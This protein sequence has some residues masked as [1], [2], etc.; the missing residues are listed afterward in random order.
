[1]DKVKNV[2]EIRFKGFQDEWKEVEL[3]EYVIKAVDNRGKTPLISQNGRY[4]LIEVISL[5]SSKP[6]YS[7]CTKYLNED[8]FKNSLRG[9]VQEE[10]I[11]FSTVGSIGLVS[12]MDDNKK[13]AIAQNIVAFRTL[14][15]YNPSFVFAMF[16]TYDNKMRT[17]KIVMSAVQPSIKVSQL[18]HVK[19]FITTN[20]EEQ[21][22]IGNLLK[23]IDKKLE[24][25]KE[26]HEKLTNFKKAMLEEVFPKEGEN[27]PKVRF[28]GFDDEWGFEA[29]KNL[30]YKKSAKSKAE[31]TIDNGKFLIMDMGSVSE[32]GNNIS[33]KRTNCTEDIIDEEGLIMP[34]DDIGGGKIIGRTAYVDQDNKYVLSD[35]VYLLYKLTEN[36]IPLFAT[37]KS[38]AVTSIKKS[39]ESL[40][41]LLN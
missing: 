9:Y 22:K 19:Y 39:N 3:N 36:I 16:S 31:R 13:A 14:K 38:I 33:Y 8:T 35:H 11:L 32:T 20:I 12:L 26:N 10:D 25:E 5:G 29:I 4:P 2:P 40:R 27:V 6:D 21:T 7:K 17:S 23:N 18:I 24:L 30:F 34:K 1:M 28:D 15:N 41:V 37:I